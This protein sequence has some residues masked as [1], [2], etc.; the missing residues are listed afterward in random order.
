[1]SFAA[2]F[3]SYSETAAAIFIIGCDYSIK[4]YFFKQNLHSA[5]NLPISPAPLTL[6][7]IPPVLSCSARSQQ[8]Y[9]RAPLLIHGRI[10]TTSPFSLNA[11]PLL[12]FCEKYFFLLQDNCFFG[13]I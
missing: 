12:I 4:V 2:A 11:R 1:M 9:R 6:N 8:Y 5:A 13:T 3:F 10:I 7:D